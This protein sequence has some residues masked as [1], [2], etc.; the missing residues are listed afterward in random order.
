MKTRLLQAFPISASDHAGCDFEECAGVLLSVRTHSHTFELP[1]LQS[2]SHHLGLHRY[3]HM[4]A[5][6]SKL[7]RG[8][9]G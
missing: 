4:H 1:K 8:T 7:E 2:L 9:C 3:L 6:S 5:R